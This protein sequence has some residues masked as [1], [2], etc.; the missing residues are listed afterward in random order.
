MSFYSRFATYYES[1]FPFSQG[2]YNL[3]RQY[4][5]LPPAAVLDVGCGTGHYG[6]ALAA[7]GYDA[8]GVDLD[9]EMIAYARSHYAD[10]EFHVMN[11]LDIGSLVREFDGIF[12]IGNTA[13]HLTQSQVA[14]FLDQVRLRLVRGGPWILQVMNW[15]YVLTQ[16]EVTLPLIE[17]E[18]DILFRRVYRDISEEQVIFETR[19]E[20]DGEIIFEDRTPLYPLRSDDIIALHEARGFQLAAH[21]GSYGGAAFDPTTFSANILIFQ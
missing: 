8:V 15:D 17:A 13:A 6:G 14:D 20:V 18:G 5:P 1:V 10:A 12:C 7:H 16:K 3:L 4:L 11:M 19:L 21:L 2:V 9:A